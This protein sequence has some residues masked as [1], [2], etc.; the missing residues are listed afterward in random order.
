MADPAV[1]VNEGTNTTNDTIINYYGVACLVPSFTAV[2]HNTL[3]VERLT[4]YTSTNYDNTCVIIYEHKHTE[5]IK[6]AP[7]LI[8]VT[9]G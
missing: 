9:R 1:A 3:F 4:C 2:D 5:F 8:I 6:S 7:I